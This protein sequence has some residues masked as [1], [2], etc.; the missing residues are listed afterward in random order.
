MST[1]SRRKSPAIVAGAEE[2][3]AARIARSAAAVS[4]RDLPGEVATKVKLCLIDF[5]GC[6]FEARDLPW[7]RQAAQLAQRVAGDEAGGATVIGSPDGASCADAAFANAVMG[8]GLVR[9]DMHSGSISH[10]GIVVLPTLLALAQTRRV[11]GRDFIAATAV[12]YEVGGQIGRAVMDAELARVFRPTGITGPVGAA[13]AGARLLGLRAEQATS[14]VAIGANTV[15]G[16]NQWAHTGGSEM[17]FHA[18]FAARNA[19][20]AVRLAELGAFA[21]PSALDGEAGLFAALRK[22]S[23]GSKVELFR[24]QPEI[25]S[26]YHKPV[27]ACNFAQTACQAALRIA[28]ERNCPPDRIASIAVRVPRAGALYP[29]CDSSGPFEHILQAKMSIQY[30]VAAALIAGGVSEKNFT[31]L[32]DT[33]LRRL[34]GLTTLEIDDDMTRAYPGRQGGEVEVRESGGATHRVR[35]DDVVNASAA[36]V[37]GRF[38]AATEGVVGTRR[39]HEIERCIDDLEGS[40]DVGRLGAL[41]GPAGQNTR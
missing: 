1:A 30:N 4:A 35:L 25:L 5:I 38:R 37:R 8:H 33:A 39:A 22:P 3:L 11:G 24:G 7:S 20:T 26:V 6:A 2:P 40:D 21:S 34:V 16:F 23:A 18:G 29:G 31:L 10:L 41:L 9:E 36:D 17:F 12:G 19:V 28:R 13:A 14:A 27:P 32:N 15:V